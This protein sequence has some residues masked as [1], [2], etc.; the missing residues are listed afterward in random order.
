MVILAL[1]NG[2]QIVWC[3][4]SNETFWQCFHMVLLLVFVRILSNEIENF[5]EL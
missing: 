2:A 4:H 5:L 3:D 1:E